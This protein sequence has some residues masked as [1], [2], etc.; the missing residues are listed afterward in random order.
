MRLLFLAVIG[1]LNFGYALMSQSL[2]ESLKK[3]S[4]LK[5]REYQ[6]AAFN[7]G[8]QYYKSSSFSNAEELFERAATSARK[9]NLS[10]AQAKSL[11][12]KGRAI[13]RKSNAKSA[14]R[15]AFA[16]FTRSNDVTNDAELKLSNLYYM[17]LIAS[18]LG[19]EK[20]LKKIEGGIVL[21][22]E[23][24]TQIQLSREGMAILKSKKSQEEIE[25][26]SSTV[27][28]LAL[29]REQLAL[30]QSNLEK[31]VS[32]KEK[33]IQAMTYVQAKQ[34]VLLLENSKILD[35]MR[36]KGLLDSLILSQKESLLQEQQVQLKLKDT[37]RNLW[38]AIA[39][40]VLVFAGAF[41][42]RL[43]TLS[44][45]NAVLAEKNKIIE[46]ERKKSEDLLLNILP[47]SI[48]QELKKNGKAE[49]RKYD[50]ATVLFSDFVGF[51]TISKK[52]S[53]EDLVNDLDFAFKNFDLIIQKYG[54]E[55]I[56]T[57]GDAYMCAGGIPEDGSG[58]PDD[59]ILAAIDIQSFLKNW[60]TSKER[61]GR[62]VFE[63]R[64]GIHTGSIV[65]GVVGTRKFAYD[66]WGDTVNIAARIESSSEPGRINISDVTFAKVGDHFACEYRGKIVAKN[67]GEIDMYFVNS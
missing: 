2:E 27:N 7:I 40:L 16:A 61:I 10:S 46:Q 37:Q 49:A 41:F 24:N 60:N 28:E 15:E 18:E 34:Q 8:E 21:L 31:V 29:Q 6:E 65:A 63:A 26:L 58:S 19:W 55:K 62:P 4:G 47:N 30:G 54:L 42:V 45:H 12:W 56:K 23:G 43:F 32:S 17:R 38:I 14:Q 52:M 35:S 53:P 36:I 57:I 39:G 25:K 66:I 59:V 51:S 48:A 20:P 44:K 5:D 13:L 33:E 22:N 64:I 67:V 1:V 11:H 50:S 3:I 9:L